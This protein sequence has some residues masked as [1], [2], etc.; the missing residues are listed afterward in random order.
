MAIAQQHKIKKLTLEL[1]TTSSLQSHALQRKCV[2]LINEG[3]TK[4]LEVYFNEKFSDEAIVRVQRIEIDLGNMNIANWEKEFVAKCFTGIRQ[5]IDTVRQ[6][7]Q[8]NEE[9]QWQMLGK[10]QACIEQFFSFLATGKMLWTNSA[11]DFETWQQQ[12][13]EAMLSNPNDFRNRMDQFLQINPKAIERLVAQFDDSFLTEMI[14]TCALSLKEVFA[15]MVLLFDAQRVASIDST[16]R[17]RILLVLLPL[18][19]ISTKR[20]EKTAGKELIEWLNLEM[21]KQRNQSAIV[22]L[23]EKLLSIVE[24]MTNERREESSKEFELIEQNSIFINNAGIVLLHPFLQNFFA[25]THLLQDKN[26]VNEHVQQRAVHLLQYLAKGQLQ[27][28]EYEMQ[29]NKVL[30]GMNDAQ[31]VDRLIELTDV[32]KLEADELL[33]AVIG[34]WT[35]LKNSSIDGLRETF[36]QRSGKLSF[37]QADDFWKLQVERKGMDILLDKMPWGFAHV[38]LPWMEKAL[39]VEW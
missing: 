8:P 1:Q 21:S 10:E 37:V 36:L 14:A 11:I 35:A 24:E 4:E 34:H 29:L 20:K 31:H 5:K 13:I 26:F 9:V 6:D 2:Q 15:K 19:L 25:A 16:M 28:P 39:V 33:Q 30:C 3:L 22:Q 27:M 17:R 23:T 12:I 32:E 7:Q 38:Q 18:I